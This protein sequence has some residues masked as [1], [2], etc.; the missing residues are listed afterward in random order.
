MWY[1]VDVDTKH[2]SMNQDG[3]IV[4]CYRQ[5]RRADLSGLVI[6][7]VG[8]LSFK[9]WKYY[10][11]VNS[12][13]FDRVSRKLKIASKVP[14]KATGHNVDTYSHL[15]PLQPI[16]FPF[17]PP[18]FIHM[19]TSHSLSSNIP[20]HTQF[21]SPVT[22]ISCCHRHVLVFILFFLS[23]SFLAVIWGISN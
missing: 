8:R 15:L 20:F 14:K 2:I 22:L 17:Y 7:L 13:L 23:L 5:W 11:S 9:L 1:Y 19:S 16:L 6:V 10:T 21:Y 4:Y 18:S 3:I 12:H